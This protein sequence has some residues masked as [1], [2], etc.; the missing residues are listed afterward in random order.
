MG[1]WLRPV[2][3]LSLGTG[4]LVGH[5]AAAGERPGHQPVWLPVGRRAAPELPARLPDRTRPPSDVVLIRTD[6]QRPDS[7]WRRGV[8]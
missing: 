6:H 4:F 2:L 3:A 8:A 1:G 5:E 7:R